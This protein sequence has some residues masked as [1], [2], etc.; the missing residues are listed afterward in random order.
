MGDFDVFESDN[1]AEKT[2]SNSQTACKTR[3]YEQ[4]TANALLYV[5][6]RL[7]LSIKRVGINESPDRTRLLGSRALIYSS[8]M[9]INYRSGVSRLEQTARRSE[10]VCA[11]APDVLIPVSAAQVPAAFRSSAPLETVKFCGASFTVHC[12]SDDDRVCGEIC[13]PKRPHN[14][15][16]AVTTAQGYYNKARFRLL[17]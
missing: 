13:Q 10:R 1:R 12:S 7:A 6:N 8:L 15:M 16:C 3:T 4:P 2:S 17:E 11:A 9:F 5:V 14:N